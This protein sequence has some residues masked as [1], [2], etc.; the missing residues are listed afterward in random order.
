MTAQLNLYDDRL[1]LVAQGVGRL[2]QDLPPGL[3]RIEA[4]LLDG[5]QQKYLQVLPG[6]TT[7]LYQ[8]QWQAQVLPDTAAPYSTR[9][10]RTH[11]E[12]QMMPAGEWS[13][14]I[15]D[16]D[17]HGDSRIF[18]F[19]RTAYEKK[20]PLPVPLVGLA[21]LHWSDTPSLI[22]DFLDHTH[23]GFN[24]GYLAYTADLPS[25]PYLLAYLSPDGSSEWRC[26]PIWL[27][28]DFESQI[29][30]PWR[31]GLQ[32]QDLSL[33]MARKGQ[34]FNYYDFQAVAAESVLRGLY[35]GKNLASSEEMHE[36]LQYKFDNPWLGIL[37]AYAMLLDLETPSR[38]LFSI[39]LSNL[40][41][42]I[43]LPAAFP[44][45]AALR[46]KP[47]QPAAQPFDFP[48]M[49]QAGLRKA[50]ELDALFP[51][52][53]SAGSL[54]EYALSRLLGDSAWTAWYAPA[55]MLGLTSQ[56]SAIKGPGDFSF[57]IGEEEEPPEPEVD[58]ELMSWLAAKAAQPNVYEN[59]ITSLDLADLSRTFSIPR[60]KLDDFYQSLREGKAPS[61]EDFTPALQAACSHLYDQ[62]R[63]ANYRSKPS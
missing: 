54:S 58:P 40:E 31:D 21:L 41:N 45:L 24:D 43:G 61:A 22:T 2:E 55:E 60:R 51:E 59:W 11:H 10:S 62:E 15:T 20:T 13:R 14:K 12:D 28:K 46:L 35:L 42:R 50:G 5:W 37:G 49:I 8:N 44:D 16:P 17:Q 38:E 33:S 48:P 19:I 27:C 18:I 57:G 29:F 39:V 56:E 32:L 30:I 7:Y 25:G 63:Y 26:Q 6:Q 23:T 9:Y 4:T 53:L 34:G 47:E 36:L 52:T 3:Y 1:R